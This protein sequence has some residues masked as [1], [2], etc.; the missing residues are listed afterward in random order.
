MKI[1]DG[2]IKKLKRKLLKVVKQEYQHV[3]GNFYC[4]I[5]KIEI[6]DVDGFV[7]D[8]TIRF[9]REASQHDFQHIITIYA[10]DGRHNADFL[11][12]Q[13]YQKLIDRN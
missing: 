1:T 8:Y 13:F 2:T 6:T 12:G 9:G 5:D 7:I 10:A 3:D 11:A 4:E